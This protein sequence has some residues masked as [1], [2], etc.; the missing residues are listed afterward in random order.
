MSDDESSI[1]PRSGGMIVAETFCVIVGTL[2]LVCV[3]MVAVSFAFG[4]ARSFGVPDPIRLI[5]WRLPVW[6]ALVVAVEVFARRSTPAARAGL[7]VLAAAVAAI[8]TT[9]VEAILAARVPGEVPITLFFSGL[10]TLEFMV[11]AAIAAF[12][13]PAMFARRAATSTR[14]ISIVIALVLLIGAALVA[15]LFFE[16]L[17]VYFTLGGATAPPPTAG[18]E[19][20]YVLTA[21]IGLGALLVDMI[22]AFV[23][24]RRALGVIGL[25]LLILGLLVAVTLRVPQ[26]FGVPVAPTYTSNPNYV[27]C[28]SGSGDCPGG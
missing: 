25:I 1:P 2:V 7:L 24:R 23:T 5:G 10:A 20:R 17:Q 19:L 4:G 9:V 22:A 6:V 26:D 13:I 14:V 8:A 18:Q 15:A 28:Y 27:P 11:C 16:W 3:G 12:A 21:S